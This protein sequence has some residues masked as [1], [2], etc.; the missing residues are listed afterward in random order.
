MSTKKP[1]ANHSGTDRAAV[2]WGGS[3]SIP[4][5]MHYSTV[6]YATVIHIIKGT[7]SPD[8]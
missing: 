7:V 3:S 6:L 1:G 4:G 8:F 2:G 5:L